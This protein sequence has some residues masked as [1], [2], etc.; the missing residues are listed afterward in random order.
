MAW[1]GALSSALTAALFLLLDP[2]GVEPSAQGLGGTTRAQRAESISEAAPELRGR[3]AARRDLAPLEST[4]DERRFLEEALRHER[5]RRREA[6]IRPDDTGIGILRRAFRHQAD[7]PALMRDFNAFASHVRPG[8][9]PTGEFVADVGEDRTVADLGLLP[10]G[11]EVIEFGPGV[12]ELRWKGRNWLDPIECLEIRGAGMEET[13]LVVRNDITV[14]K[15]LGHMRVRDLSIEGGQFLD[16]RGRAAA[17]FERVRFGGGRSG[18]KHGYTTPIYNSGEA[19]FGFRDCEFLSDGDEHAVATRGGTLILFE[20]CVFYRVQ[21][22]VT[23]WIG[24]AGNSRAEFRACSWE[25]APIV[26]RGFMYMD[27][28]EYPIIVRGG[29]VAFGDAQ[30]TEEQRREDW[31]AGF[32]ARLEGVDFRP[33]EPLSSLEDLAGIL[34]RVDVDASRPLMGAV[35]IGA[36]RDGWRRFHVYGY[37][38]RTK[39]MRTW[40]ITVHRGETAV[41]A[42][43][44]SSRISLMPFERVQQALSLPDL[45]RRSGRPTGH[46]QKDLY[47]RGLPIDWKQPGVRLGDEND[48]PGLWLDAFTGKVVKLPR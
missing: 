19:Y 10:K 34:E 37:D 6:V 43:E 21:G 14:G 42:S 31:G 32:T 36:R 30:L 20:G 45:V 3:P 5:C 2:R 33:A 11:T 26:T 12:F 39:R 27:E 40:Q 25:H 9:G 38:P 41:E 24:A 35:R 18:S 46:S 16:V 29:T 47:Y 48:W 23:G 7:I 15:T 13:L 44:A 8:G 4:E 17:I 1:V 22:C 28:P